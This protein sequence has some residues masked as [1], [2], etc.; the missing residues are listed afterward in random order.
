[1]LGLLYVLHIHICLFH[2]FL[3]FSN[4]KTK[5]KERE[6]GRRTADH[7]KWVRIKEQTLERPETG[8]AY[9][10]CQPVERRKFVSSQF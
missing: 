3:F 5:R 4:I 7:I 1:M 8:V 10:T 9:M 6:E 2:Y